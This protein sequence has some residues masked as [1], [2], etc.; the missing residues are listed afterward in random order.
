[1]V[2]ET[3]TIAFLKIMTR[4]RFMEPN[5]QVEWAIES[6]NSKLAIQLDGSRNKGA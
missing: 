1:M 4:S 2:D 5:I 3:K 6:D